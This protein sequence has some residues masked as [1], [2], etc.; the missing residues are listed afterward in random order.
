[1]T[2]DYPCTPSESAE[3]VKCT[4]HHLGLFWLRVQI[5]VMTNC[6]EYLGRF[7]DDNLPTVKERA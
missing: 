3:S 7:G 6:E 1:V 4:S 5:D 2:H